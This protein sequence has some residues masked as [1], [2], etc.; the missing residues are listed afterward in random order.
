MERR[1]HYPVW[2]LPT[3]LS[4]W[5]I[6]LLVLAQFGSGLFGIL[7]MDSHLWCGYALLVALLFRIMWGF[8]GSRS[9][10]FSHFL[11]GP[12]AVA[13]YAR[14]LFSPQ[15]SRWP[16]HNPLGGWSIVLMLALALAQCVTG[17]FTGAI[18]LSGPL[19][20]RVARSTAR[21]AGDWHELLYWPLLL[22][23]LLHISAA[24]F[25]LLHKGE[26]LVKPIFGHGR[27]ALER[28]PGLAFAGPLRALLVLAIAL[29]VVAAVVVG[30][31]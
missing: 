5:A 13:A 1:E 27:L 6:A 4:H 26:N 9:A 3:R 22:L 30:L 24:L 11:R 18:D 15:P 17:L 25:H 20:E 12:G 23:V 28:D 8:V 10:R 21:A 2:D 19:A 7:P 31:P 29:G 16:G 14:T